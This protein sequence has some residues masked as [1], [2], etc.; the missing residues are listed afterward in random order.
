[1]IQLPSSYE[2]RSCLSCKLVHSILLSPA[3][4]WSTSTP[5]T[6]W[7]KFKDAC[8]TALCCTWEGIVLELLPD[9]KQGLFFLHFVDGILPKLVHL[10]K[11]HEGYIIAVSQFLYWLLCHFWNGLLP[12]IE[13]LLCQLSLDDQNVSGLAWLYV[14]LGPLNVLLYFFPRSHLVHA[15]VVVSVVISPTYTL[16]GGSHTQGVRSSYPP[17]GVGE[18]Q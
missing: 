5:F 11:V 17:K 10:I 4:L 2:C 18:V 3:V 14:Y 13:M 1:M 7:I 16:M 15:M 9:R 6:E 12:N 8:H